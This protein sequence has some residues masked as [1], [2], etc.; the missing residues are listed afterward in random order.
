MMQAT[1]SVSAA[2]EALLSSVYGK[3]IQSA[4]PSAPAM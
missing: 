3:A 4:S 2:M 1:G